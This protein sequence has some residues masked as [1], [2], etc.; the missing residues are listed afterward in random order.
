MLKEIE[1]LRRSL[2]ALDA[3]DDDTRDALVTIEAALEDIEKHP[4]SGEVREVLSET[5][6]ALARTGEAGA[7]GLAVRW[8]GL[9]EHFGH[10]EEKHPRL[11]LAIG[12]VSDSLAAFGL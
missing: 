8:E 5:K 12:R 4:V 11:V 9:K 2:I 1:E 6:D 7:A 10:W 3:L